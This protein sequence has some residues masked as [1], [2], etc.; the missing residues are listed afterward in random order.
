MA[1][2]WCT[3]GVQDQANVE[4]RDD[5]LVYTSAHLARPLAIAGP[6]SV[7]L[8]ASSSAPDTDFTAKLVDVEPSGYCANLAEGI[9]RVRYRG[10]AAREALLAPGE[11]AELRIDL[12]DVAHTFQAGH[13]I[14]LEI[15]SSNFP[16]YDRNPNSARPP[17][18]AGPEDL[19]TAVQH[20][21]H[22]ARHPSHL[23]L[24][25]IA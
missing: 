25:V 6:V 18:E 5:V 14:R 11:I 23:L 15:S 7:V 2:S 22:D 3:A 20:V 12:L 13:R 10:G 17:A 19:A 8:F 21:H 16:K 24:P 1:P 9:L 4:E